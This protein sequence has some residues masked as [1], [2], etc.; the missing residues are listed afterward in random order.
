MDSASN[1]RTTRLAWTPI[2]F[3]AVTALFLLTKSRIDG[4]SNFT[5]VIALA[6]TGALLLPRRYQIWAPLALVLL[7]DLAL[8]LLTPH[9]GVVMKYAALTGIAF[10]GSALSRSN[11]SVPGVLLR[12]LTCSIGF[13]LLGNTAAWIGSPGYEK[14]FAGWIQANTT[15]LPGF[16]PSW[17]FLRNAI[18]SDQIFSLA[19][20]L[21]YNWESAARH[22]PAIHWRPAPGAC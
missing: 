22:L 6:F 1:D 4:L 12:V 18:L 10:W 16:P 2:V 7:T 21:A 17:L 15:G 14:S 3:F 9:W 13:Y 8:G 19:I 11:A 20:L 5:P